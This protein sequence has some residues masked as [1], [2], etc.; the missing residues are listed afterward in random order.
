MK[1]IICLLVPPI[2]GL[3]LSSCS[4]FGGG[5]DG[6]QTDGQNNIQP[7]VSQASPVPP[8]LVNLGLAVQYDTA[9]V[10][11][12]VGQI[13]KFNY[14]VTMV[15]NDLND[16]AVA[17]NLT[18]SGATATCPPINTV[19]NLN[20]RLD[21]G[22]IITCTGDYAITQADLDKGSV[23]FAA[24]A[25]IYTI[26]SSP[27]TTNVA[28]VP[29]KA[30]SLQKVADPASYY[31]IGLTIKFNYTI[32][33]IGSTQLA[34][35]PFTITDSAINNNTPF[36]CGAAD[37]TIAPTATLTCS[38]TYT[39]TAA[40]M[41]AATITSTATAAGG[42]ANPSQPVAITLTK[43]TPPP[44]AK[45]A[46]IQHKVVKGEWLWQIARCYGADPTKTVAANSQLANPAQIK[47]G[48]IVTVPNIGSNGN[49]YAPQPC[50]K[51]HVV[52]SGE[53][54][55]SIA[56]RD[57][58]DACLLQIVNGN[59]ITVGKEIKIPL[60][61]KGLGVSCSITTPS[62][63]S[64]STSALTL[65]FT[66]N[67]TTYSQ[68]GQTI[69]LLYTIKNTGTTNLGPDQFK[70][71]D[72]LFNSVPY[73]CGPA[74]NTL[75]PG[76]VATCQAGYPISQVDIDTSS[77]TVKPYATGGGVT[78]PPAQGFTLTKSVSLLSLSVTPSASTYNQA[79]QKI[80]LVY[81]ITNTG[82]TTLGPTQFT[83]SEILLGNQP[84]NCGPANTALAPN[85]NVT[86]T[87]SYTTTQEDMG[88]ASITSNASASGGG[89]TSQPV[90]KTILKQ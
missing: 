68:V 65:T 86:C 33:N 15:K 71:I 64:S 46:T 12:T 70:V 4:L 6:G 84:F 62:T 5:G 90:G 32:K 17:P 39:I 13:I 61:T 18:I 3:V 67:P 83:V 41:N 52:Q 78:S 29:A 10:Y 16:P 40:D 82:T 30:L 63:T 36:T 79:G 38:Q 1:K 42:G 44:L 58:A 49:I 24:T 74:Q 45:G 66:A 88:F 54:W 31:Q 57:G 53:T 72:P 73:N 55:S 56:D 51:I 60:Y 26:S 76:A 47:E 2:L 80:D 19:G 75:A 21:A 9:V 27:I 34:P 23:S 20:D 59:V 37:A 77:I 85:Q 89:V 35:G 7:V 14:V 50:V 25:T 48:M 11:N 69:T 22:E 81:L 43:T 87:N 28:T 8:D